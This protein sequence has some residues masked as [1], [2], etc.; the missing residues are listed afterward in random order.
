MEAAPHIFV[1][2]VI[3]NLPAVF[4]VTLL[5]GILMVGIRESAVFN[6]VMVA[7]KLLV[8]SFFVIVGVFYIKPENWQPFAP[9][10]WA[11]IRTGAAVIFF[12]FFGFDAVSTTA[13]ECKNPKRDLPIGIMGSLV[14]CTGIYIVVPIVLTGMVPSSELNTAEPL[15]VA[16]RVVNQN[17][18]AGVVAFGSIVDHTAVL[19]V[20]QLGQPRILFSM[21][22]DGLLPKSFSKVHPK[23]RTPHVATMLTG[24]FVA[25]GAAV[26]SLEEMADLCNIGTLSAFLL[27]CVGVVVLRHQDPLRPRPFRVPWSPVLPIL[28]AL[29][30]FHLILGLPPSAWIRFSVWLGIGL[31]I[32]W[33]FGR[34]HSR[35]APGNSK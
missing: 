27:V 12:A 33:F 24:L 1:F 16:M 22:R 31:A 4:I 6:A 29:A 34:R 3:F 19:L 2:P 28:G 21:S 11:G 13:E 8:L 14:L 23:F 9:N 20:F 7:I 32:Y 17:W 25:V 18:V 35:L 10:G 30:C 15:S 26:A 5:T